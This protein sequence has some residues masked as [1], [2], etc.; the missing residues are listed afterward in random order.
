MKATGSTKNEDEL[1]RSVNCRILVILISGLH[2]RLHKNY[3]NS[4]QF[5]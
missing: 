2:Q 3:Y 5:S 4:E 1:V